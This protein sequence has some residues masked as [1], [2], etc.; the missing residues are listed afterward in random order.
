MELPVCIHPHG[1]D[2]IIELFDSRTQQSIAFID[3]IQQR[4]PL[5]PEAMQKLG[6]ALIECAKKAQ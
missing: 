4:V 1:G 3:T 2:A 5:T 6:E